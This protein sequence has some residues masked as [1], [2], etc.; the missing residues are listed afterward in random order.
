MKKKIILISL[1]L[2]FL[3]PT[4]VIYARHLLE[5]PLDPPM[6]LNVPSDLQADLSADELSSQNAKFCGN[7]GK[8][9][10]IQMGIASPLEEG[11]EGADAIRL[12]MVDFDEGQTRILAIPADLWV[13]TP[14]DLV[15][16]L[17]DTAPINQIYL[18]AYQNSPG[19][20]DQ[21]LTQKATEILAQTFVDEFEFVPDKYITIKGG[22]FIDLIDTLGGITITLENAYDGGPL[23]YFPAGEQTLNGE[24]TLDFVRIL[25]QGSSGPD[26]FERF[27]RQ[28]MVISSIMNAL[29][30]PTNWSNA[31]EL[32]KEA[33]KMVVT[34]LSVDQANDLSCMVEEVDGNAE[35]LAVDSTMVTIDEEGHMLPDMEKFAELF[36]LLEGE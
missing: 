4:G 20:P 10:I 31:P 5:K 14:D 6:K 7:S 29:L 26:Y 35:F 21:V 36:S 11:H 8:M 23:G 19:N 34:D 2:I 33:R 12:V 24:E 27:E 1:V 25:L 17:G 28:N 16:Y 3:I 13:N 9:R 18:A 15:E 32:V 22:A 30:D